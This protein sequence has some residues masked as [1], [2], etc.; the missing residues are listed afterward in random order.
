V[1]A[2]ADRV[3]AELELMRVELDE[4]L[5]RRASVALRVFGG[6][7]EDEDAKREL[8]ELA[9]FID[10]LEQRIDFA[11]LA[12]VEAARLEQAAAE[13]DAAAERARL[14]GEA[15]RLEAELL[16]LVDDVQRAARTTGERAQ[17]AV[18]LG[19]ELG[20]VLDALGR[21]RGRQTSSL[22]S[23]LVQVRIRDQ[24]PDLVFDMPVRAHSRKQLLEAY[25]LADEAG[26]AAAKTGPQCSVCSHEAAGEIQAALDSGEPLREL[27]Q[28][29]GVSKSALSRHR[30]HNE[31]GT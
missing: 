2:V 20:L 1:S 18:A 10:R 15:V 16:Q 12:A 19:A 23:D 11:N 14:E 7:G 29:Y 28:R 3:S 6:D 22:L 31:S 4:A 24:A 9:G 25:P 5:D 30:Q 13:E 17:A 8:V 27:E 26:D 21:L